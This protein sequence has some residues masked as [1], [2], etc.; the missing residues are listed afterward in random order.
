M[1]SK[2]TK[3]LLRNLHRQDMVLVY[4]EEP[5]KSREVEHDIHHDSSAAEQLKMT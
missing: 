1:A 5:T 2:E 4:H 3:L